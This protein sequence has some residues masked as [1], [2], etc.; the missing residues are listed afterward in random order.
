VK[1][2]IYILFIF[3]SCAITTIAQN[4]IVGAGFSTGWGG[5]G[6][7][8]GN[9]DF[10]FFGAGVGT[11]Y[12]VSTTANGT[13]NQY[14]RFGVDWDGTTGQYT[15]SIGS[16][17]PVSP[18]TQYSLNTTCTTS[19]ALFYSVPSTS[20]NYIFKT[21]NAGSNPTGTFVF[22]EVQ[23]T[24]RTIS[25]A[26]QSPTSAKSYSGLPVAVTASLS[27][28][29]STGQKA[30]LRYTN[31]NFTTSTVVEMTGTGPCTAT[32]PADFNTPSASVKYYIFTS[33]PNNVSTD[34]ANAD[35]FTINRSTD[36]SY[37]VPG[38]WITTSTGYWSTASNWDAGVTPPTDK[39][40]GNIII[41]HN[42]SRFNQNA[43]VSGITINNGI[44]MTSYT[45][46]YVLT[47]SSG[48]IFT[49][50]GTFIANDGK[51]AFAGAGSVSGTVAFNNVDISGGVDFGANST[52]NGTLTLNSGGY[53]NTNAP[54]YGVN[55]T[56]KY[57]SNFELA[58]EWYTT[59]SSGQGVPYN[60][61]ID[62]GNVYSKADVI[63]SR[64][65]RGSL[66]INPG[67]MFSLSGAD[68]GDL[69]IGGDW[70]NNGTFN[71]NNRKVTFNGTSAQNINSATTFGYVTI[72]NTTSFNANISVLH[73]LI[74][75][76][77]TFISQASSERTLTI[78]SGGSITNN[79]TFTPND[80]W[81]AFLG[82]N[83]ITGTIAFNNASVAN[84]GVN[85]GTASTINT[86]LLINQSGYVN[87]NAPTY[88]EG[89]TL[90]Y[91]TNGHYDRRVEWSAQ[92]GRG[93]PWH[94]QLSNNTTLNLGYE[95]PAVQ[96]GCAGNLTIDENSALYM[97]Y[98]PSDMTEELIVKG[99]LYLNGT[100]SLSDVAGGDMEIY[101]NWNRTGTFNPKNRL[102]TFKGT[103]NQTINNTT[104]FDYLKIENSGGAVVSLAD[105]ISVSQAA[106][107]ESGAIFNLS[108]YVVSGVGS[109]DNKTG[110]TIKIGAPD[111]ISIAPDA[112]GNV[113]TTT[114]FYRQD[115][116]YHYSGASNQATGNGLTSPLYSGGK[117]IVELNDNA[118]TLT[119]TAQ[120]NT[121]TGAEIKI[122]QGTLIENGS[123]TRFYGN[124]NLTMTG[125]IY[126]FL[127]TESSYPDDVT[128]YCPKLYG[129]YNLTGGIIEL[130]AN[131]DGTYQVLKGGK[132]Y[133]IIK[134]SGG[135]ANNGYKSIST[136]LSISNSLT[137]T[138]ATTIFDSKNFGI[139]GDGGLIMDGGRF[140]ISK[141]TNSQPELTGINA[142]Y[143]ITGG[144]FELY[145]TGS[146]QKQLL[147]GNYGSP[148]QRIAY[149]NVELNSTAANLTESNPSNINASESFTV[150][151]GGTVT[152]NSP[153]V[154]RL[155]ETDYIDGAG[156]VTLTAGSTL[157][158]GSPNGI[159][160]SGTGVNDG[161]IR[162]SGTRTFPNTASYGF[163]S[164]GDMN[165]G[166][167]LPASILNLY[168]FKTNAT[169]IVTINNS[170]ITLT[171]KLTL[172]K[173]LLGSDASNLFVFSDDASVHTNAAGDNNEPGSANSFIKGLVKKIGNDA[174]V[175]PTG[176]IQ[177]TDYVWAPIGIAAP[178]VVT[179]AFSAKYSFVSPNTDGY[180]NWPNGSNMGEELHHVSGLEYWMFERNNGTSAPAITLYWKD[181][182]RS[183]IAN[184]G[185]AYT[186][187]SDL[188]VAHWET[189]KWINMGGTATGPY[190]TG[191]IT[192]TVAFTNYSPISFGSKTAK[193]P[194][195]V[196]LL[197]F[198]GKC[199][200]NTIVLNW[201]TATEI[202]NNYFSVEHSTDGIF[203]NTIG[204]VK[205]NGN[206][207]IIIPYSFSF[208]KSNN[209]INYFR[210]KQVD[211]NRI[212]SFSNI[213]AI[214]CN[215]FSNENSLLSIRQN[216]ESIDISFHSE[217]PCYIYFNIYDIC[218]KLISIKHISSE[219]GFNT[220]T[221]NTSS[222]SPGIYF[223][224][225]SSEKIFFTSKFLISK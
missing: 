170:G 135:S 25:S 99:D 157:L 11:S 148:S 128:E 140:R 134:I 92:S 74:N 174:F 153:T 208:K 167:A 145:G 82:N 72:D 224:A 45:G 115:A 180:P 187:L 21:L 41:A 220:F 66:T 223:F 138:D 19:G 185:S 175:F 13:G 49:N 39:N 4:A 191:E 12:F 3:L 192:S 105:N 121:N 16:D 7:P 23:G 114:R 15:V 34:G 194:L 156:N 108:T 38:G 133:Y 118:T 197:S 62:G 90:K 54:V 181:A 126:K 10:K 93:Y 129:T 207:N 169:D 6:C 57:A 155:D 76:D 110:G 190:P 53:V 60:V 104:A 165:T 161:N 146:T 56:L 73:L 139:T 218:G 33:G 125:G 31:D 109:F 2:N 130:A 178:L 150:Q 96:K 219:S 212:Y 9:G 141:L 78:L 80:G 158:F 195:P 5:G 142:A 68:F 136:A 52:I 50:N 91:W 86:I 79:G 69:Y 102:V 159:K 20:Y 166:D 137:I 225:A 202:N 214:D 201:K 144:T 205:G 211:Y 100:L 83:S 111:G 186:F 67:K 28:T 55:S 179:D 182:V 113:Q 203:F 147:R 217:T 112:T 198:N 151:A 222:F 84:D 132:T 58:S 106:T 149:Y 64:Y 75:E 77:K 127:T 221:F 210:L 85:F 189:D 119:P 162:I 24:V 154:F 46:G 29:L 122:I 1:K 87:I 101:G 117:I 65:L 131:T 98:D 173:G 152:V 107:V 88:A 188:T 44:T 22:F 71:A 168:L 120:I 95:S 163:V 172:Y 37:S 215:N 14:W 206:S 47:I 199:E 183:D 123:A 8:T 200:D 124:G 216:S 213:I 89:S 81:V 184:N 164:S 61:I 177:G 26:S 42:I 17:V 30:Y 35:L 36:Y 94:V 63:V 27:G 59:S 193:N 116:I 143:S 176:D 40:L 160:T 70:T 18:S 51:V 97:D 43:L 171:E 209:D 204:S 103:S 196:N 32:I 48:G